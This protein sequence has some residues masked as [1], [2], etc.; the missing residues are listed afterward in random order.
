MV[1]GARGTSGGPKPCMGFLEGAGVWAFL[2]AE[3]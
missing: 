3:A 1:R 2:L